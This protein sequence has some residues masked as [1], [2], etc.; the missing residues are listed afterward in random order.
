MAPATGILHL[1]DHAMP[2]TLVRHPLRTRL[3]LRVT[4][5]GVIEARA[6]LRMG[7]PLVE[8]FIREQADWLL[9]TR[10]A[11]LEKRPALADGALLTLLNEQL[12]L[13]VVADGTRVRRAGSILHVPAPLT[14]DGLEATLERWYRQQAHTHL[15]TRLRL[16]AEGMGVTVHKLT[17]RG[18]STR[19]GS[20]SSKGAISLNWQL[21]LLPARV[22]DYVIVHEL[23][24]RH[25]MNHSPAFWARVGAV[26]PEYERLRGELKR[27]RIGHHQIL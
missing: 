16:W 25:E 7:T 17:I 1:G 12:T 19:W 11:A 2:Y 24:H 22:V 26:L 9:S 10:H 4:A 6:P 13:R 27:A 23:C 20:C 21:M 14:P 8:R 3:S 5:A 18:Q 15:T